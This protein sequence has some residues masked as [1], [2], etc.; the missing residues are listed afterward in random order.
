MNEISIAMSK[1][2]SEYRHSEMQVAM[3]SITLS[4]KSPFVIVV[5]PTGS[6][7]TWV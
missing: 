3:A 6:G 1:E 7:K 5:S 4:T 2:V